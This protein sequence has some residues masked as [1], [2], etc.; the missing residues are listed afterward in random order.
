MLR[1]FADAAVAF[2]PAF[3]LLLVI[4]LAKGRRDWAAVALFAMLYF[5]DAALLQISHWAPQSAI[6]GTH[7]NWPGKIASALFAFGALAVVPR[8]LFDQVGLFRAPPRAAWPRLIG[9]IAAIVAFAVLRGQLG[10][11]PFNLETLA[12]QATLPGLSEEPAYRGVWWILLAA[13][14]DRTALANGRIPWATLAVTSLLFGC[15]HGLGLTGE[16]AL[17]VDGLAIAS[18]AVSGAL[19][20]LLQG[21]GRAL[22]LTIVAH[23]LSNVILIAFQMA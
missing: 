17:R 21:S 9:L 7:W 5:I 10:H 14:I 15:V 12:F 1:L 6:A 3:A 16:G 20:G 23:N 19:Y 22:W 13:A 8:A 18:T 4:M 2:L 11:E